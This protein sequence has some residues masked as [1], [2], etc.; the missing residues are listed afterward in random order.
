[1]STL[2]AGLSSN[3]RCDVC[4]NKRRLPCQ[5]APKVL[6]H[7]AEPRDAQFVMASLVSSGT[8]HGEPPF[9]PGSASIAS[10]RAGQVTAVGCPGST[11]PWTRRQR[12]ARG[13]YDVPDLT[14][15]QAILRNST[16]FA[17]RC[18]NH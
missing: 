8:T 11:S 2:A 6:D 4:N 14:T 18:P 10:E 12:T 16:D 9:V 5:T 3:C 7:L 13:L 1:M 17:P 15:R